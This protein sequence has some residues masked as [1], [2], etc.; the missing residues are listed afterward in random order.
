MK[1]TQPFD[2]LMD[3]AYIRDKTTGALYTGEQL[4]LACLLRVRKGRGA[5]VE[6]ELEQIMKGSRSKK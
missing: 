3:K 4:I 6:K 5:E 2:R 1:D